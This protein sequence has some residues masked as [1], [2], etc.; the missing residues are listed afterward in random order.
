M[1]KY[2][3]HLYTSEWDVITLH[4]TD[5]LDDARAVADD[6]YLTE[7]EKYWDTIKGGIKTMDDL[8]RIYSNVHEFPLVELDEEVTYLWG[9]VDPEE[10]TEHLLLRVEEPFDMMERG[11][12]LLEDRVS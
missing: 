10:I 12:K 1:G 8:E 7:Y 5:D 4:S 9:A 6:V 2:S 3:V 11:Y